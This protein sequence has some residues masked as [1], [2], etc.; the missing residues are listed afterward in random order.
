MIAKLVESIRSDV[1]HIFDR[2]FTSTSLL[3]SVEYAAVGT[4]NKHRKNVANL[5]QKFCQKGES[6]WLCA[7]RVTVCSLERH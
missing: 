3:N 5:N 7:K 4:Y 6:E 2:F 1:V